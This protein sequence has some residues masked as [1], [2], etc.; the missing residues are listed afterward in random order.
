MCMKRPRH[1][2]Q[3]YL[4]LQCCPDKGQ[5]FI[6]VLQKRDNF[7]LSSIVFSYKPCQDNINKLMQL[8]FLTR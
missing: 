4:T 1:T 6:A 8:V 3:W 5:V 7:L 2:K